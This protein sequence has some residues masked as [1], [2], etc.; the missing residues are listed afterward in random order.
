MRIR[1]KKSDEKDGW[2]ESMNAGCSRGADGYHDNE[3]S[4][5]R[6]GEVGPKRF[7][8]IAR[9]CV[10]ACVFVCML[11]PLSVSVPLKEAICLWSTFLADTFKHI[12]IKKQ[13]SAVEDWMWSRR[14]VDRGAMQGK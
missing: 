1:K 4:R 2:C 8:T 12:F 3:R 9:I 14:V 7:I 11:S 13:S 10:C 5:K 6:T